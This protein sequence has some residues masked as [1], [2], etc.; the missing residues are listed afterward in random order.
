M[1]RPNK[2]Q[3]V[4]LV[5][6]E[7]NARYGLSLIE[8]GLIGPKTLRALNRVSAVS[9]R[10]PAARRL[11]GFIQYLTHLEPELDD[12]AIDGYWGPLTQNAYEQLVELMVTGKINYWRDAYEH[13]DEIRQTPSR[14]KR[15]YAR[16]IEKVYGK[17]GDPAMQGKVTTPYKLRLAW[18]LDTK[19]SRFTCHKSLIVPIQEAMEECLEHYGMDGLE[20]LQLTKGGGCYNFRRMRGG[21]RLSTHAYA[22]A[23]DFATLENP[24]RAKKETALFAKPEYKEFFIAW[25]SAGFYGLGPWRDYDFQHVQAVKI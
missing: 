12:I 20:Q 17:A 5:Q 23:I 9:T 4:R 22:V 1:G 19:I 24:L 7:L 3:I 6:K 14:Y 21:R 2:Q 18:D 8:D 13:F 16:D 25:Q 10:W 11:V 15:P